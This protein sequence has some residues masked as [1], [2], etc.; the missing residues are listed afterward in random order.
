LELIIDVFGSPSEEEIEQVSK[1]KFKKFLRGLPKKEAKS[2][3]TLFP[4]ASELALDLLEKL[5]V[6]EA[7][8]RITVDEAL[9]HPYL[10]ALHFP[11]DEVLL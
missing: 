2:L 5:M 7:S 1:E 11:D 6:F 9:Q 8:K 3:Q 10:S 4:E